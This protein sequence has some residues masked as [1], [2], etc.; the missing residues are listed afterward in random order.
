[1]KKEFCPVAETVNIIGKKWTLMIIYNLTSGEKRFNE[2][3][4]SMHGISSKTLSASLAELT[5]AGLVKREVY[6]DSPVRVVYSLTEKG[7][8]LEKVLHAIRLWGERW[9]G[10]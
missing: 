8:E 10:K 3:K 7:M 5:G 2:L 9:L 4:A 6:P 1:M